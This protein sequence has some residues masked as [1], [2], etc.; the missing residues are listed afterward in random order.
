MKLHPQHETF[1]LLS[2]PRCPSTSMLLLFG[3]FQMEKLMVVIYT[4]NSHTHGR[5]LCD[6]VSF[7]SKVESMEESKN[8]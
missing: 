6:S 3:T 7:N 8:H 2:V 4:W 1:F 5:T